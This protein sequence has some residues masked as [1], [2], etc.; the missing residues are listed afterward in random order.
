MAM[1]RKRYW[2]ESDFVRDGDPCRQV[3]R[4]YRQRSY[5]PEDVSSIVDRIVSLL[6]PEPGMRL[7]T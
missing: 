1:D 4:T 5:S 2:N 3:G 6:H 7:S